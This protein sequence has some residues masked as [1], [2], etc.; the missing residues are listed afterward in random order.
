[1]KKQGLLFG[2]LLTVLVLF[3]GT[4]FAGSQDFQLINRTGYD[5]YFVYVSPSNSN[6]WQEDV[7]GRDVLSNGDSVNITFPNNERAS[8]WDIKAEFDDGSS[9]YWRNLNLNSISTVTLQSNGQASWR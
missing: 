6:D 2:L 7:M 5:I 1:M 8:R 9:L 3:S 4:A